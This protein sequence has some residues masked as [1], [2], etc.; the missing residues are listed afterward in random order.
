[1][2]YDFYTDVPAN[3]SPFRFEIAYTQLVIETNGFH[4]PL[5]NETHVGPNRRDF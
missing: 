1:M 3:I 5:S 4:G 2:Q